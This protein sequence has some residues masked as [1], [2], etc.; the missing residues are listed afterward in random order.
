MIPKWP[1]WRYGM[2][3]N[4]LPWAK[5]VKLYRQ[6]G[7]WVHVIADVAFDLKKRIAGA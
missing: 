7:D 2:V 4:D 1:I 3:G 6:K 5:S